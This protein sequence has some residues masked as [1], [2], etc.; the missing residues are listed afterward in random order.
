MR[1]SKV[2]ISLL[3][4]LTYSLGFAHNLIPHSHEVETENHIAEHDNEGHHH[5]H[6]AVE[7]SHGEHEHISHGDHFDGGVLDVLLC[8]LHETNHPED[9]CKDEHFLPANSN[10]IIINKLQTKQLV[11]ILFAIETEAIELDLLVSSQ[12]VEK[13]YLSPSVE[14]TPLRGPPSKS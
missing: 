11:T 14:D 13:S 7:H 12:V 6:K 5:H 10:R 4:L 9:D 1:T 8:V 2:I 3:L